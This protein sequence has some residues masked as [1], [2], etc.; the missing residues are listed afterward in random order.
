MKNVPRG[1]DTLKCIGGFGHRNP[2]FPPPPPP[3]LPTEEPT[4]PQPHHQQKLRCNFQTDAAWNIYC[5]QRDA[6]F[7]LAPQPSPQPAPAP[8]EKRKLLSV[9]DAADYLGVPTKRIRELVRK[10]RIDSKRF[11]KAPNSRMYIVRES[12]DRYLE[13]RL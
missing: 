8:T 10:R 5:R 13:A 2:Y 6:F 11:S 12:I 9:A 3:P 4:M 7:G 1:I